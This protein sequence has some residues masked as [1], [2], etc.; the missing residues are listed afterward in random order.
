MVLG[1]LEMSQASPWHV[2]PLGPV[3]SDTAVPSTV[4][5][6]AILLKSIERILGVPDI[7]PQPRRSTLSERKA[8]DSQPASSVT[9]VGKIVLRVETSVAGTVDGSRKNSL[10]C[11]LWTQLVTSRVWNFG[12]L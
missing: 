1:L 8:S 10:I 3:K 11:P 5:F 2:D 7:L 9:P 6:G 12:K 4:V